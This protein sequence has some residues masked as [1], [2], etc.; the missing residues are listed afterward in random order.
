MKQKYPAISPA[1]AIIILPQNLKWLTGPNKLPFGID[2][3]TVRDGL[4]MAWKIGYITVEVK[5]KNSKLD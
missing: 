3:V 5:L 1:V 2:F 4:L